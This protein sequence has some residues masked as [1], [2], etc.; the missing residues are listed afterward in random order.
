MNVINGLMPNDCFA[1]YIGR[2]T[3]E[4][5]YRTP[6]PETGFHMYNLQHPNT[7]EFA[8]IFE[9]Y[10]VQ[11]NRTESNFIPIGPV[12]DVKIQLCQDCIDEKI[13]LERDLKGWDAQ[14]MQICKKNGSTNEFAKRKIAVLE[15][16]FEQLGTPA[17]T[18]PVK[19]GERGYSAR[20]WAGGTK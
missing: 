1:M 7:K 5:N 15:A 9:N 11:T 2:G 20:D 18:K 3:L 14:L 8:D 13:K 10:L 12:N 17:A 19:P 16:I 4:T 6:F